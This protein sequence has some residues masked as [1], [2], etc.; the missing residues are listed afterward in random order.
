MTN[1]HMQRPDLWNLRVL[2]IIGRRSMSTVS[3]KRTIVSA[4]G[5]F[6]KI[7]SYDRLL[8]ISS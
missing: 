6:I 2:V 5:D 8:D 4:F 7:A 3:Q 1:I